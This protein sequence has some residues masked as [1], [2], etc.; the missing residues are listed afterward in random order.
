MKTYDL[1]Y[2][3]SPEINSEEAAAFAKEVEAFIQSKEGTI[4][5]Q[6]SPVAKTLAFPIKK[7]ASGFV[8]S[9][10]FQV[11]E[12]NIKELN[13]KLG[14]DAKVSRHMIVIKEAQKPRKER[15]SRRAAPTFTTET[16]AEEPKEEAPAK[17]VEEKSKVELK[18]I[19]QK[20]DEILGE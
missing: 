17:V 4:I 6:Q 19:E 16:K 14:K 3:I 8:G 1:T 9:I 18:D 2:I 20:L 10:E 5:K 13:E 11:E 7:H 15:G 12:E